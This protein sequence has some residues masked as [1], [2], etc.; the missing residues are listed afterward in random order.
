MRMNNKGNATI[1]AVSI[2]MSLILVMSV[3]F[4]YMQMLIISNGIKN[5]VQ[6]AVVSTV[7]AN[8]DDSYSQLREGYSGGFT[9]IDTGFI[10]TID[11]WNVYAR[12]DE[13][14]ALDEVGN[15]HIKYIGTQKEYSI[16]NLSI[17][18]ENTDF[19][20]DDAEKNL[21][22]TVYLDVE[23][24]VRFGGRDLIPIRYTMKVKASY[25]PKF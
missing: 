25:I 4:E 13:L 10:E 21:N 18:T 1:I 8:Y 17:E 12:L 14:L 6:S 5:A 23:I 19:A 15:E 9:Y 22:A 2:C 11:T 7:V 16:S 20:Q 3:I 24:P